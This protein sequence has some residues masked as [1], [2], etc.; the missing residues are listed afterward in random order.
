LTPCFLV[1]VDRIHPPARSGPPRSPDVFCKPRF[2]VR[3]STVSPSRPAFSYGAGNFFCQA[4]P[5][6]TAE[7]REAG[8]TEEAADATLGQVG[9]ES[10]LPQTRGADF[11]PVGRPK[12]PMIFAANVGNPCT[13][14]RQSRPNPRGG[15]IACSSA[16]SKSQMTCNSSA[17]RPSCRLAAPRARRHTVPASASAQRPHRANGGRD[18]D[19]RLGVACGSPAH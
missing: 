1:R 5:Q 11:W 2:F 13:E 18:C 10:S 7:R 8:F 9:F 17:S 16:R 19:G 12:L 14:D 6:A 15:L 4:W 3:L